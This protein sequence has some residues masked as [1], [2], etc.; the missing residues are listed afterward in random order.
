MTVDEI[1]S[2]FRAKREAKQTADEAIGLLASSHPRTI[3]IKTLP[4]NLDVLHVGAELGSIDV[5]RRWPPPAREDLRMFAY[6]NSR[7]ADLAGY[8]QV[9]IGQFNQPNEAYRD[10]KFGAAMCSMVL[11]RI[12]PTQLV[13]WIS[14]RTQRESRIFLEWP[15]PFSA[16]LPTMAELKAV[17]INLTIS[18]FA[19]DLSHVQMHERSRIVILLSKAGF[20]IESQG[21]LSLPFVEN[22]IL[23]HHARGLKDDYA[24]QTA[25]WSKTKWV[26]YVVG[27]RQ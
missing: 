20:F 27:V 5:F 17:N 8:E 26:Q 16:L 1:V 21:Y 7:P 13:Q 4:P 18:N 22:E 15:S 10:K 6:V 14:E 25:F 2:W 19:D 11:Q 12:D 3:F 24:V 9:E 23:A